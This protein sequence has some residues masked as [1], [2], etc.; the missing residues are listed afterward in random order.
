MLEATAKGTKVLQEG[1]RRRVE[2]LATAVGSL[3][4]EERDQLRIFVGILD[5]VIRRL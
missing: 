3:T 5:A 2:S 4:A 1:R